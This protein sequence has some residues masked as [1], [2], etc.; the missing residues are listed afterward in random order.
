MATLNQSRHPKF[1][2][3]AVNIQYCVT[4]QAA[5]VSELM[6]AMSASYES[7]VLALLRQPAHQELA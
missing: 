4:L 5:S 1:Y 2:Y 6:Q 7:N 3:R